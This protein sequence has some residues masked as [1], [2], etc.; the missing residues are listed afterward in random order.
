MSITT[1]Y[2]IHALVASFVMNKFWHTDLEA[3]FPGYLR[4][5]HI[6][7][8]GGMNNVIHLAPCQ[9]WTISENK[10][11]IVF[12]FFTNTFTSKLLQLL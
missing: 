3:M 4:R 11:S 2:S 8:K 6:D 9:T 10:I 1:E 7:K 12:G 5:L